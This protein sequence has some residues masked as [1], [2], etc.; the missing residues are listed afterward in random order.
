[1]QLLLPCM[2]SL[3]ISPCD[4][5]QT[6]SWLHR[7]PAGSIFYDWLTMTSHYQ[8][9]EEPQRGTVRNSNLPISLLF[10]FDNVY[11]S[12]EAH[13]FFRCFSN[14]K[15]LSFWPPWLKQIF[16]KRSAGLVHQYQQPCDKGSGDGDKIWICGTSSSPSME[17]ALW[18]EVLATFPPFGSRQWGTCILVFY[19]G[20]PFSLV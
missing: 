1:M 13:P 18:T 19:M 16:C 11:Q 8:F 7:H 12:R 10:V 9:F 6:N 15:P 14:H 2:L 3:K 20:F 5:V 17:A 4:L